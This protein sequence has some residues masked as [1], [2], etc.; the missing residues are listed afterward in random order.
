MSAGSF[1]HSFREQ[2]E[3]N[4]LR[5]PTSKLLV[6]WLYVLLSIGVSQALLSLMLAPYFSSVGVVGGGRCTQSCG[7]FSEAE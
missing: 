7:S 6:A 3:I 4:A 2:S 5:E 1:A